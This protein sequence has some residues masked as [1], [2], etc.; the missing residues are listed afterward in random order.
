MRYKLFS[1]C[2][3]I[4]G[5]LQ[6]SGNKRLK[7]NQFSLS[8]RLVSENK[9]DFRKNRD[10]SKKPIRPWSIIK[11]LKHDHWTVFLSNFDNNKMQ[12]KYYNFKN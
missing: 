12:T 1:I 6:R 4:N 7:I 11:N 9:Y 5:H 10:H 8:L 3:K 2:V